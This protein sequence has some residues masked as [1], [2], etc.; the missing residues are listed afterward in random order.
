V[1]SAALSG[2]VSLE[3]SPID[4]KTDYWIK[5]KEK[6]RNDPDKLWEE[7]IRNFFI[8]I[9]FLRRQNLLVL[10]IDSGRGVTG[11]KHRQL[12]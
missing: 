6:E 1:V 11:N 10:D 2:K 4:P 7:A 8:G 3:K 12:L 9:A 5:H